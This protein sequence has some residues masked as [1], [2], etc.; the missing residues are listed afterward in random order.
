MSSIH[1]LSG[2]PSARS[3]TAAVLRHLTDRFRGQGHQVRTTAV[4]ELPA[5]ALLTA[6]TSHPRIKH[7]ADTIAASDAVVVAS[8]V[9]KAAYTGL[10]KSLLDLLPQ[11]A[12]SG[13]T[14]LP[15]ATGGSPAHVLAIDYAFRPMLNS[16]GAEHVTQGYF[17]LDRL[18]TVT[19]QGVV[20]DPEA[21][22]ALHSICDA[23][24]DTLHRRA[25]SAAAS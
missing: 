5:E 25:A 11:F 19:D 14:V 1:I 6:D 21:E 7:V 8:P 12:L 16:L 17:L 23:F 3:R 18:I 24:S 13:K 15:L 20:L 2:S 10:L 9:Y 22:T 4:R